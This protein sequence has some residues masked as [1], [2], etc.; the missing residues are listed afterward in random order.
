VEPN[1]AAS[2][3]FPAMTVANAMRATVRAGT[4]ALPADNEFNF[5]LAPSR[6]VSVLIIQAE[7][8]GS[9][10]FLTTALGIGTSPPFKTDVVS[11]SRV[12]PASFEKRSVVILNDTTALSTQA[13]EALNRFVTQG[14]GLFIVMGERNP[15]GGS[16]PL[17]P[18]KAGSAVERLTGG[19]GTLGTL[20]VSHPVFQDFKDP[21][22]GNFSAARFFKYR[23]ITPADTD[24]VLARFDDGAAAMVER[25]VGS[26]RVILMAST[27]DRGWNSF[28]VTHMF[29]P[30]VHKVMAYLGQYAEPDAWHTVGRSLDVSVPIAAI[31]REGGAGDAGSTARR[32]TGVVMSPSG[33]QATIGEGGAQAVDLT[34]QGFYSVRLQGLGDRKPFQVAVNLDPAESDLSSLP[35]A[36]LVSSATG[37]A[38]VTSTGRSLEN[39]E[40][41][42]ADLEKKQAVWWYLLAAAAVVLLTEAVLANRLSKRFGFGLH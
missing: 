41:T 35:P 16:S 21:K 10:F 15:L 5:V 27:V 26:G 1:A 33:T 34:E 19:G 20:D 2:V 13:D 22:N 40:D 36:E 31:V 39:P 37:R 9:S 24:K 12:T 38:A 11:P 42:P 7:G 30:L 6:P 18:G 25:A 14:G 29:L 3:T 28:P 8:A 32:P 17:M 23:T 4:D